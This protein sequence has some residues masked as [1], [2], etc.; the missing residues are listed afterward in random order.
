VAQT[1]AKV[2]KKRIAYV[3]RELRRQGIE[4]RSE[5]PAWA[6]IQGTLAR[7]DRRLA[8]A[9][10]AVERVTPAAWNQALATLDLSAPEIVRQRAGQEPLPWDM[11]ASAAMIQNEESGSS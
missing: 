10:L 2:V 3:E 6:Q 8:E 11:V 5:S 9:L 7:G 1:P 4:V